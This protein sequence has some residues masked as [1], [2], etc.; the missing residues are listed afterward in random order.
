MVIILVLNGLL[1]SRAYFTDFA[2]DGGLSDPQRIGNFFLLAILNDHADEISNAS[3]SFIFFRAA[4]SSPSVSREV[5]RSSA[6]WSLE[7]MRSIR[8]QV[9]GV[10]SSFHLP[11]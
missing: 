9:S 10:L 3:G 6:G 8:E 1:K 11:E 4:I 2:T 5:K 7:G